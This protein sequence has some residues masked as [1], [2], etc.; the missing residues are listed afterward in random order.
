MESKA[1]NVVAL[2]VPL[3]DEARHSFDRERVAL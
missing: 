3:F 2:A 1:R